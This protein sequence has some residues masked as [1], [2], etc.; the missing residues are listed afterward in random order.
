MAY[1]SD[2]LYKAATTKF[3]VGKDGNSRYN[4]IQIAINDAHAYALAHGTSE[5][6][7]VKPGLYLEDLEFKNRVSVMGSTDLSF[8]SLGKSE[9]M[10]EDLEKRIKSTIR[11]KGKHTASPTSFISIKNIVFFIPGP[12]APNSYFTES[13]FSYQA[14]GLGIPH[15]LV[16]E[17]CAF[18]QDNDMSVPNNGY[19]FN[20]VSEYYDYEPGSLVFNGCFFDVNNLGGISQMGSGDQVALLRLKGANAHYTKFN[21]CKFIAPYTPAYGSI[22]IQDLSGDGTN[23]KFDKCDFLNMQMFLGNDYMEEVPTVG[24]INLLITNSNITQWPGNGA[25]FFSSDMWQQFLSWTVILEKCII[26]TN[27]NALVDENSSSIILVDTRD[28]VFTSSAYYDITNTGSGYRHPNSYKTLVGPGPIAITAI[29]T[30]RQTAIADTAT[31]VLAPS[32]DDPNVY[33]DGVTGA[34]SLTDPTAYTIR[35]HNTNGYIYFRD[36]GTY[37]FQFSLQLERIASSGNATVDIWLAKNTTAGDFSSYT[38][39]PNTNTKLTLSGNAN[40]AK[41]VAAWNF[42]IKTPGHEAFKLMWQTTDA[43]I[44]LETFAANGAIPATPSVIFT[45]DRIN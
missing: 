1:S 34:T 27:S 2:I 28:S 16:L 35:M 18:T 39:V 10:R 31:T 26:T 42:I 21:N 24:Y 11:V 4:N 23:V 38:A 37:N 29:S 33:Y 44:V 25:F 13:V 43:N 5:V 40:S 45:I 6:V 30:A 9:I 15:E 8:D 14:S 19:Y 12:T 7:I 20:M 3:I 22:W 41:T 17:N 32:A 36:G